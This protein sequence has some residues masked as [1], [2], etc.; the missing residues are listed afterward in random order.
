MEWAGLDWERGGPGRWR[1]RLGGRWSS[2]GQAGEVL[3]SWPDE[4]GTA[5]ADNP[6]GEGRQP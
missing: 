4:M 1:Q 2:A 5:R 6:A 3:V